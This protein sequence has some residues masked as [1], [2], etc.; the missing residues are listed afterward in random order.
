MHYKAMD[1][2]TRPWTELS[3]LPKD[4]LFFL[5]VGPPEAHGPH[6]PVGTD[7]LIA[8]EIERAAHDR[9]G[10]EGVPT[11]SL[12]ALPI[13]PCRYLEGFPGSVSSPWRALFDV[14][15]AT[16]RSFADFDFRHF[17][18]VTFH[19]DLSHMK[20]IHRAI[21]RAARCGV[22][23]CE[24]LGP[25][26]F[27]GTLFEKA[28][29]EVHADIKE[30]SLMLHLFPGLVNNCDIPDVT[31]AFNAVNS[32]KRFKDVGA[33]NGYIGCPA[34]AT[35]AYGKEL[36]ERA[37]AVVHAAARD[38]RDGKREELPARLRTLLRV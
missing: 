11:A 33:C 7:L 2:A 13:G 34:R 5:S 26:Y 31:V 8:T 1:I 30:T 28:A 12:P 37:V 21:H 15:L 35:A 20:A 4:T 19:M 10:R 9:L 27:R 18:V 36:F 23:A 24:P 38:V 17:V 25:A 6:L 29:G 3:E 14:L 16:F 22:Y 32:F